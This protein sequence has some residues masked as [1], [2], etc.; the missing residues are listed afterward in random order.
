MV[1]AKT[2]DD[3]LIRFIT[4]HCTSMHVSSILRD[5]VNGF[6]TVD[7]VTFLSKRYMTV[8]NIEIDFR[9]RKRV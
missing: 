7:L 6:D 2:P 9:S 3:M 5:F 1:R 4:F 8:E